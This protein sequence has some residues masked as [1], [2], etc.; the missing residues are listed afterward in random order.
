MMLGPG[1]SKLDNG[2]QFL[3]ARKGFVTK[4]LQ[5]FFIRIR[6]ISNDPVD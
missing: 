5:I 4:M 1:T 3:K 2:K 6:N